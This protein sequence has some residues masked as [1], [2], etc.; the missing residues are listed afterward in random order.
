MKERSIS[1][2]DKLCY[3]FFIS[4][5]EALFFLLSSVMKLSESIIHFYLIIDHSLFMFKVIIFCA[6]KKWSRPFIHYA[7]WWWIWGI[8]NSKLS[9]SKSIESIENVQNHFSI[10]MKYNDWFRFLIIDDV[11]TFKYT[12]LSSYSFLNKWRVMSNAL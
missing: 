3:L 2:A 6:E 11:I 12:N 8:N 5:S 1:P 7:A 10:T 9:M 4:F